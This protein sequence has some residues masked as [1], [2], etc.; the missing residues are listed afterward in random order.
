M[1]D[2]QLALRAIPDYESSKAGQWKSLE[3]VSVRIDYLNK[4]RNLES[5]GLHKFNQSKDVL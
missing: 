4:F 3:V 2:N 1:Y 5:K